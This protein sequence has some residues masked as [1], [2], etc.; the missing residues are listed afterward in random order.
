MEERDENEE[1]YTAN[2]CSICNGFI[3]GKS[4][5]KKSAVGLKQVN[6]WV[7]VISILS[8]YFCMP[9]V[10]YFEINTKNSLF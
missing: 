3:T 7:S 6:T 10:F 4:L 9:E 1:V 5:K 8:K 2:H